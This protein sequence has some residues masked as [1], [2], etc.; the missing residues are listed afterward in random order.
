MGDKIEPSWT[1][2]LIMNMC[3]I[4]RVHLAHEKAKQFCITILSYQLSI[5]Q[6]HN[7]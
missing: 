2:N 4:S 7:Y 5:V 3:D 6:Y 1:L